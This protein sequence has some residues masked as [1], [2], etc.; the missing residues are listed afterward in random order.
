MWKF[1]KKKQ[2][3]TLTPTDICIRCFKHVK[4]DLVVLSGKGVKCLSCQAKEDSA[5][6]I[7]K[8]ANNG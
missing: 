3:P 2:R 1:I 8:E 7:K 6:L 5:N 4:T